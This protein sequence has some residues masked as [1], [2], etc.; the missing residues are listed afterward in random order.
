LTSFTNSKHEALNAGLI[1]NNNK[2]KHSSCTRKTIHPTYKNRGEG[3][4]EQANSFKCLGKMANTD[5][6]VEEQIKARIAAGN[7]SYHVHTHT[8]KK[9]IFIKINI[10]KLPVLCRT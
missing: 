8:Q 7:R 4:F 3:H 2:T 6:S 1:V 5:H 9:T 10:P